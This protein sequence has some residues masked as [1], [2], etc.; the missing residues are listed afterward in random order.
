MC[1]PSIDL[2]AHALEEAGARGGDQKRAELEARASLAQVADKLSVPLSVVCELT[3]PPANFSIGAT[4][5]RRFLLLACIL[6][7]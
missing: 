1:K 6:M 4:T 2:P 7:K 5:Y 3:K